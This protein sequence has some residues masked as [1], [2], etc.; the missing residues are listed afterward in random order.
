MKDKLLYTK[1]DDRRKNMALKVASNGLSFISQYEMTDFKKVLFEIWQGINMNF[2]SQTSRYIT[3]IPPNRNEVIK[4]R[5]SDHLSTE[6]EWSAHEITGYPNR[7]YSIVIF[8][9]KSMPNES[10]QNIKELNWKS[11]IANNI[12]V[13]EKAYNRFYLKETFNNLKSFIAMILK[14][15]N[16]ENNTLSVNL[17]EYNQLNCNRNMKQTIRL[18]E[19]QLRGMIQE[20]VDGA[21]VHRRPVR[22]ANPNRLT[23]GRLRAMIQESVK[24]ALNESKGKKKLQNSFKS[25]EDMT[26]YRDMYEPNSNRSIYDTDGSYYDGDETQYG[27]LGSGPYM[28]YNYHDFA[29]G[30][31][32]CGD[33]D[34]NDY[35]HEYNHNLKHRL[36]TK[37]GQMSY[38]WEQMQNKFKD[39]DDRRRS[40]MLNLQKSKDNALQGIDNGHGNT[41][42]WKKEWVNGYV[43]NDFLNHWEQDYIK[44]YHRDS[45]LTTKKV[46]HDD[47]DD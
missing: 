3:F 46:N 26:K 45:D 7:R 47:E 32:Y 15:K 35:A 6:N 27:E 24:K 40:Y 33:D 43:D 8:S 21:M 18:T 31:D 37:G 5:I 44:K 39:E 13:Y 42:Y 41:P 34:Y 10:R 11:Y 38:D 29:D 22:K 9:N 14:G 20:A 36:A 17:N 4:L 12:P 28:D 25:K 19:S 2:G 23:E 30:Y 16:P 1:W